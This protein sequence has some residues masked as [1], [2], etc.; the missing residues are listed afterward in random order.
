MRGAGLSERRPRRQNTGKRKQSMT[1]PHKIDLH[2]HTTVSDG[3]DTPEEILDRVKENGIELFAVSDHDAIKGCDVIQRLRKPDDPQ[4]LTGVEEIEELLTLDNP[5]KPH[6]ANLMVKNGYADSKETAMHNYLNKLR[7]RM[8]FLGPEE[9]IAGILAGGGIPVLAHPTYGNGDQLIQGE[10]MDRRLQ[11]L[12]AYGLQGVEGFYSGF[13]PA[14]RK[15]I[16][17]FAERYHLYVTAGSDYHG[18]NKLIHLGDT[19]LTPETVF[20]EGLHRFL[21]AIEA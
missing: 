6:L 13:S 18:K 16:L 11:R 1:E 15:E 2:M 19:G 5:G 20:P 10:N 7:I 9:A 4:F 21:E 14:I 12:M 8:D 17:D 3:T